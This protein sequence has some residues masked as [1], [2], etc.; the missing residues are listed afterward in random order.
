[1]A[2]EIESIKNQILFKKL[3]S[4]KAEVEVIVAKI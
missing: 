2:N 4:I 1:M 3:N